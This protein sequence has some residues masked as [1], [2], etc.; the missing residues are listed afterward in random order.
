MIKFTMFILTILAIALNLGIYFFL[1]FIG[2][3]T[4]LMVLILIISVL[5]SIFVI[6]YVGIAFSVG[7]TVCKKISEKLNH[8]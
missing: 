4:W 2:C 8:K 5:F 7:N 6:S 3:W 1:N